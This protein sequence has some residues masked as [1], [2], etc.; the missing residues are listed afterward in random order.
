MRLKYD[1][2]ADAVYITFVE[3]AKSENTYGDWPFHVDTDKR[4]VVIGV[5]IMDAS[6]VL[7]KTYIEKASSSA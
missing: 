4:G 6:S 7:N 1:K 2:D 3:N 5:E